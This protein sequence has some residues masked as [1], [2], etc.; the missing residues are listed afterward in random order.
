MRFVDDAVQMMKCNNSK[1]GA[2]AMLQ[3][4]RRYRLYNIAPNGKEADYVVLSAKKVHTNEDG[5]V[6]VSQAKRYITRD[7]IYD[8]LMKAHVDEVGAHERP[9][10]VAKGVGD[11]GERAPRG[12]PFVCLVLPQVS[13]AWQEQHHKSGRQTHSVLWGQHAMAS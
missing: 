2:M 5:S 1:V 9:Q 13:N 8:V 6:D 3:W 11:C 12:L 7:D 10:D 4:R